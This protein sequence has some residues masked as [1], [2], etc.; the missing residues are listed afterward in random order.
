MRWNYEQYSDGEGGNKRWILIE[1]PPL[2]GNIAEEGKLFNLCDILKSEKAISIHGLE[3]YS[4]AQNQEKWQIDAEIGLV[5][6]YLNAA[7]LQVMTT[8]DLDQKIS[9]S[10]KV[11]LKIMEKF[12][13]TGDILPADELHDFVDK[14]SCVVEDIIYNSF[15]SSDFPKNIGL[16]CENFA[17]R[18]KW[19]KVWIA[20][21][22]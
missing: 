3:T 2:F 18:V 5:R 4:P 17:K 19:V 6:H 8:A 12:A 21:Q 10:M 1:E 13:F 9:D 7:D 22:D 11:T 15:S 16:E 14:G 20:I